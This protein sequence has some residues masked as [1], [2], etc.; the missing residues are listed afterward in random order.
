MDG[1]KGR[2]RGDMREKKKRTIEADRV[3]WLKS[4]GHILDGEG[5]VCERERRGG[6][7][8]AGSGAD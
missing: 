1:E 3:A 4:N 6:R 5:Y 8:K 7:G 2:R